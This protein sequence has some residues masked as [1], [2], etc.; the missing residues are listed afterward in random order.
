LTDEIKLSGTE[1][2]DTGDVVAPRLPSATPASLGTSVPI[3]FL[4]LGTLISAFGHA[5]IDY[6]VVR[7]LNAFARQSQFVDRSLHS[8]TTLVLLQ[9]AVFISI[10]ICRTSLLRS[11]SGHCW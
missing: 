3:V 2:A 5:Q 4:L 10:T 8:L 11:D 9:G 7:T 6:P 1:I